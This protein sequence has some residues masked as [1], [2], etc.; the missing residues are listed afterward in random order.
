MPR[1]KVIIRKDTGS[2]TISGTVA[3][4][5]IRRRAQSDVRRL[6]EEE[7]AALEGQLLKTAWHGERRGARSFAEAV[8]SYLDA[9]VRPYGSQRFLTRIMRALGDVTLAEVDLAAV[10][11]VKRIMLSSDAAASTFARSVLAPIRA[12]MMHASDL[13]WCDPPRLRAP[14]QPEG[15]TQY[16]LP[17]EATALVGAAAPHL[18]PLLLF[19]IGTGARMSEAIELAWRD[20]DLRGA[21]AILWR[22]KSGRRRNVEM[23][24][25]TVAALA[26]LPHRDGAVFRRPDG[27]PY[28]DKRRR[29]GGQITDGFAGA[30]KRAGLDHG[31]SPH[32]LRH[33]WASWHYAVHRDLLLLKRDGGW[34]SVALVERYAHLLPA[35][36]QDEI[37]AFLHDSGTAKTEDRISA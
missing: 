27:M 13:G 21:R 11:K 20:V 5:Q 14:R 25:M 30:V 31:L 23:P 12:V 3:G 33:T 29:S 16:L 35:G 1:L 9:T 28:A 32:V 19:L 4:Q 24:P 18:R 17:S 10:A 37:R 2:L 15:R 22:T 26:N 34:H 7:A 8:D 36:L 6:A